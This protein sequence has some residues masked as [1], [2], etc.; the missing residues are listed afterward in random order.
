MVSVESRGVGGCAENGG[1]GLAGEA[2]DR[3]GYEGRSCT[4]SWRLAL[5]P[6]LIF[7]GS[8]ALSYTDRG[9]EAQGRRR[10]TGSRVIA[11][12]QAS[13]LIHFNK[14]LSHS[15][16]QQAA[17]RRGEARS[18]GEGSASSPGV[19]LLLSEQVSCYQ[20]FHRLPTC[21]LARHPSCEPSAGR[22]AASALALP[23]PERRATARLLLVLEF[24]TYARDALVAPRAPT[25]HRT[26]EADDWSRPTPSS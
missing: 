9:E 13:L 4:S 15:P 6:H 1:R 22:T 14:L 11:P 10:E 12:S 5:V 8:G 2:A 19:P 21:R 20:P 25:E 18:E 16:I 17:Q 26:A 3:S 7:R 24:T 23:L